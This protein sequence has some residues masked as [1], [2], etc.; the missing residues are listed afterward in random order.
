M[1]T[2]THILV[3]VVQSCSTLCNP[4][5]CS[6]PD[7]SVRG[8]LQA[9]IL[10]WVVISISRGVFPTQGLNPSLLLCRQILYS[11]FSQTKCYFLNSKKQ[12]KKLYLH[13]YS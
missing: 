1:K 8:I 4:A 2:C 5:D 12:V 9:G 3:L 10:E 7:S 6:S 11:H 13:Y